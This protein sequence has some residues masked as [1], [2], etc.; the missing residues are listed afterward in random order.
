ML[1]T[2][3]LPADAGGEL[4]QAAVYNAEGEYDADTDEWTVT[5]RLFD[6]EAALS[7][8]NQDIWVGQWGGEFYEGRGIP[9]TNHSPN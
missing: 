7:L 1:H 5:D 6:T 4:G 9:G 8:A 2:L 3:P